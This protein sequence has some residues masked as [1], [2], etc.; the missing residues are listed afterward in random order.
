[1]PALRYVEADIRDIADLR[2]A[3]AALAEAQGQPTS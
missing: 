3:I 2:K 1:M